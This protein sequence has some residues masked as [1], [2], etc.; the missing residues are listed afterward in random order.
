[1]LLCEV[2]DQQEMAKLNRGAYTTVARQFHVHPQTIRTLWARARA[3][4]ANPHIRAFRASPQKHKCGRQLKWDRDAL[5]AAI[6]DIPMHQRKSIRALSSALRIPPT[7]LFSMKHSD[8]PVI[9]AHTNALKPLLTPEHQFQRV[10]YAVLNFNRDDDTYNGFYQT[11]HVDEK[12]FF[13]T[14]E[15]L[16]FYMVPGEEAPRRVCVNKNHIMKVMFLAAIARP[17]Y[18]NE[19]ICT[20]DG[21]IGMWPLI[22]QIPALRASRNRPRGAIVTRPVTCTGQVY[23][24]LMIEHVIPAIKEKWPCRDRNIVIQ[25]DGASAHLAPDNLEFLLHARTR[26]WNISLLTQAPK[27]PDTNICDLSFFRALESDQWRDGQEENI[28]GLVA[29]VLRTFVRFDERKN[30]FGF[31][32]LQCCL[33]DILCT[34]GGN[35]YAI[36]HVGKAR[37]LREGTL[38]QRMEASEAAIATAHFVMDAQPHRRQ[39][40]EV[41][42]AAGNDND[43]GDDDARLPAPVQMIQPEEV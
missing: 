38:P 27:S 42:E 43:N 26:P 19:G 35:D 29:Q 6:P 36:R 30:D 4:F 8:D 37:M 25:Q 18:D 1:L 21:K 39:P 33:D 34:N 17:R 40:A 2:K 31:L 32:T 11:V 20:F 14:E 7:T 12:W 16:R 28:E 13:L 41:A 23:K 9:I 3:N 15:Q 5:R 10:C 24:N 22:E